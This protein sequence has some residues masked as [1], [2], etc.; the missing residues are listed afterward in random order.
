MSA[1]GFEESLRRFDLHLRA[2]RNL[3]AHTRRAYGADVRQFAATLEP[4]ARPD[5]VAPE[6]VRRFLTALHGRRNPATLARKLASIRAFF[7]FLVREG[8]SRF[9]PTAGMPLTRTPKRLP[10]PLAVDDC[11]TFIES[12]PVSSAAPADLRDRALLELLYGA[13]LRVGELVGL[14]V[15]DVDVHRG[16][17]RVLGKGG[18]ERVVPLP[19]AARDALRAW[20]DH[21]RSPGVLGEPLFVSLRPSHRRLLDRDVRRVLRRRARRAGIAG[22]VHPH[23][24]RHSYATHLLDMGADLREIQELLGHASLA[25]TEKYT[26]VSAERLVEVYD[27]AHPRA[28]RQR[29]AGRLRSRS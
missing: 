27:R 2:E 4:G 24:L 29:A 6:D 20:L 12:I 1:A 11:Q 23:R 19:G 18:K 3:S 7:R 28:R 26:A 15:R 10:R 17:V 22:A 5:H 14:D 25:T 21:R 13:G 16:D 8:D 9:D